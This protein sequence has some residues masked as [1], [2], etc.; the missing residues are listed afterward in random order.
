MFVVVFFGIRRVIQ[1]EKLARNSIY[2]RLFRQDRGRFSV[3]LMMQDREPSPVLRKYENPKV[4][5]VYFFA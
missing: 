5:F 3:L 4:I 1:T 2:G